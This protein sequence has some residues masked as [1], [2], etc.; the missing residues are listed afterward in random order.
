[1]TLDDYVSTLTDMFDASSST[2]Q[3]WVQ[4]AYRRAVT[5]ARWFT[6][7]VTLGTTVAGQAAYALPVGLVQLDSLFI[8][9][10]EQG[11]VG[12]FDI[13]DL[14]AGAAFLGSGG[15]Y[16]QT[17]SSSGADQI[18]LY[19]TPTTNGLAITGKGEF[20]PNDLVAGTGAGSSPV[21][22]LDL[23][24][25]VLDGAIALGYLRK[26]ERPDLAGIHE[27]RFQEGVQKLRARKISRVRGRPPFRIQVQGRDFIR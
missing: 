27:S 15:V 1:M 8:N 23:H 18:A 14:N 6:E 4:E 21:F 24:P 10:V 5:D 16:A 3:G 9:G 22:P 2:A 12:E 13:P 7:T 19:P 17:S 20:V 11:R 26:D 25:V